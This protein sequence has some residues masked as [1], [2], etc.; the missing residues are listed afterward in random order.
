MVIAIDLRH[1]YL[2]TEMVSTTVEVV[3]HASDRNRWRNIVYH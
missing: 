2:R 1:I 3:H